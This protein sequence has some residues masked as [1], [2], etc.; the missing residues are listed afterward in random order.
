MKKT[1]YIL[2]FIISIFSCETENKLSSAEADL[3][4]D[5]ENEG[6]KYLGE[7]STPGGISNTMIRGYTNRVN[8]VFHNKVERFNSL[9]INGYE[10]EEIENNKW[11]FKLMVYCFEFE[12]IEEEKRFQEFQE[13][14]LNYQRHSKNK[15]E[16][17]K[18]DSKWFLRFEPMP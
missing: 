7:C 10:F 13:Y 17:F 4:S 16:F 14:V 8:G 15:V 6:Y 9:E 2:L 3:I 1:L 5:F 18:K 12:D 11:K